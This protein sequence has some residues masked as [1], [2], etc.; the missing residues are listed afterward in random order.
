MYMCMLS[1]DGT[2]VLN[3]L[4]DQQVRL[5]LAKWLPHRLLTMDSVEV[6]RLLADDVRLTHLVLNYSCSCNP[7]CVRAHTQRHIQAP[8]E[9]LNL[10]VCLRM[11]ALSQG[12]T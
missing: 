6:D 5:Y 1:F 11:C 8:R 4:L 10:G 12:R 3:K 7:T 2:Q 9:P